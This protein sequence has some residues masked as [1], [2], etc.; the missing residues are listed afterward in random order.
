MNDE[1]IK[2]EIDPL[3]PLFADALDSLEKLLALADGQERV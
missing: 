3:L 1:E 2:V